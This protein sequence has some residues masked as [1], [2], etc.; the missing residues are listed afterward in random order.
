MV[1]AVAELRRGIRGG[2][3]WSDGGDLGGSFGFVFFCGSFGLL[4][5]GLRGSLGIFRFLAFGFR[6]RLVGLAIGVL[7]LAIFRFLA[8]L[9]FTLLLLHFKF[10]T[11]KLSNQPSSSK[12]N[13]I[14]SVEQSTLGRS[15]VLNKLMLD[16]HS[17]ATPV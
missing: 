6:G 1:D 17:I 2:R 15:E 9:I 7:L 10:I 11:F 8:L 16:N 3:G 4:Y 5:L 12:H 14:S 13:R